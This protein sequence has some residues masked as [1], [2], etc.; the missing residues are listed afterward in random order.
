MSSSWLRALVG[1][2]AFFVVLV[3]GLNVTGTLDMTADPGT[4]LIAAAAVAIFDSA[5]RNRPIS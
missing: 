4:G 5:W 1:V 3:V 2:I